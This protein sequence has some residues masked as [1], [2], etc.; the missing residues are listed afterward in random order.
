M[1]ANDTSEWYQQALIDFLQEKGV[2]RD[3]RL[4]AAFGAV[5]RHLFLSHLTPQQV[6]R[7]MA[8]PVK[9][10]EQGTVISSSSQPTMMAQMIHQLQLE[11][12]HNVLE[13]GTGTGYNAAIMQYLVGESGFVT[14]IEL[15][16]ELV[17]QA[18]DNL[19]RAAI[20]R[21]R[22]VQGDGVEGYAPRAAYDRIISTV[23][24]WDV[25]RI[26]IDQLKPDGRLVTPLWLD[27][28]Q[29]SAAFRLRSN[30]TLFSDDLTPCGFVWLRGEVG[31]SQM[32]GR[33]KRVPGAPLVVTAD[34]ADRIDTV[35][36]HVLLSDD[37]ENCHL[38]LPLS[39]QEYWYGFQPYLMVSAPDEYVFA[40][41]SLLGD[42]YAAYGITTNGFGLFSATS[43]CLL[44]YD[45]EGNM[46]CFGGADTCLILQDSAAAWNAAGR[47]GVQHLR[48]RM[49]PVEQG[50][51]SEAEGKLYH[52]RDHFLH[53]WLEQ[54]DENA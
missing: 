53:V 11:P 48:L 42:E 34:D 35:A 2:L 1:G 31:E 39:G 40:S 7:D 28:I 3:P 38:G 24:I 29:V 20:E 36:I 32:R 47:P 30:G 27:G 52:R 10:D 51:P 6:Y 16:Q 43:T 44:P 22:V 12:G 49:I 21:V 19:H 23:A 17:E 13:I 46:H 15:D 25:P 26:W 41:Y 54:P 18:G 5:P 50:K 14:S 45:G 8:L 37:H 9:R 33:V 4:E